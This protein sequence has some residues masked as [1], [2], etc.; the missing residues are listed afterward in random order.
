[1]LRQD[2]PL[3]PNWDQDATAVEDDYNGQDPAT[4]AAELRGA[5]LGLA[6]AFDRVTGR[7]MAATGPAQRR[8][9]IHRRHASAA[10]WCTT[11]STIS[12]T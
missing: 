7:A 5:A 4:V 11:P 10:T 3:Y 12:S 2:D 9:R 8:R 6:E 1:M